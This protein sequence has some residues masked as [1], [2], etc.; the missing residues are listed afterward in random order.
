MEVCRKARYGVVVWAPPTLDMP[1]AELA[2]EQ[3]AGLVKDLNVTQR[4]A[5][6]SLGGSEGA[7]TAA[8]VRSHARRRP[9]LKDHS[10]ASLR[11]LFAAKGCVE[12]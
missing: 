1:H 10:R 9:S 11:A 8:D 6:L 4:F 3:V 5:G 7:M 2:V 12:D